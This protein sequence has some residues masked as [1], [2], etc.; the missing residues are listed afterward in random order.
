MLLWTCLRVVRGQLT[1]E[2]PHDFT[3]NSVDFVHPGNGQFGKLMVEVLSSV[4]GTRVG[5]QACGSSPPRCQAP[6]SPE[7]CLTAPLSASPGVLLWLLPL[8]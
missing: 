7:L 2:H 3:G 6:C 4:D 5:S 8:L 1:C